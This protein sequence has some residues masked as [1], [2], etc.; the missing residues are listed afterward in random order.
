MTDS[1]EPTAL[2]EIVIRIRL[3]V[4]VTLILTASFLQIHT[5]LLKFSSAA[6]LLFSWLFYSNI[7]FKKEQGFFPSF[8]NL[9]DLSQQQVQQRVT[10][11]TDDLRRNIKNDQDQ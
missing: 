5:D 9:K 6:R 11:R 7:F 4:M 8:W 10:S 1:Q 2:L 3:S